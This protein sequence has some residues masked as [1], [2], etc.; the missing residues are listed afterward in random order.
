LNILESKRGEETIRFVKD[1]TKNIKEGKP[2]EN[3][4][5]ELNPR[6]SLGKSKEKF[7]KAA[8]IIPDVAKLILPQ[9]IFQEGSLK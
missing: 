8:E 7:K 4:L 2:M 3:N 9:K 6:C 1:R 5:T